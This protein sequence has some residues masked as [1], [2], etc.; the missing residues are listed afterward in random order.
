M[1]TIRQAEVAHGAAHGVEQGEVQR[2]AG[3][4]AEVADGVAVALEDGRVA[5]AD[6]RPAGVGAGVV[7]IRVV[8][9]GVEVQAVGQLVAE[10][11][12]GVGVRLRAAEGVAA[13]EEGLA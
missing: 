3:I 4:V 8:A 10:A 2:A 9:I 6:G 1:L 5:A 7:G 12:I 13:G 11:V